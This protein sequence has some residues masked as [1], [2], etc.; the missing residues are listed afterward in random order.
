MNL[1]DDTDGETLPDTYID[2][3]DMIGIGRILDAAP[4]EPHSAFDL[5]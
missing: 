5:F 3:I 2:K 1:G 4:H